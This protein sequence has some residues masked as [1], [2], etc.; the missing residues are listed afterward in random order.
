MKI[1]S[2]SITGFKAIRQ[3]SIDPNGGH[4]HLKGKNHRGKSSVI[5]SVWVALTGKDVPGVP[6]HREAVKATVKIGTTDGYLVEWSQTT[7]GTKSLKIVTPDG[8]PV[9]K[10]PAKFLK[11]LVGDISFDPME[12]S[13]K[14]PGEQKAELQKILGLDFTAIE[15]AKRV[16]LD[17]K[18]AAERRKAT[19]E[20]ELNKL[21]AVVETKPVDIQDLFA[22]QQAR[23]ALEGK[24]GQYRQRLDELDREV[25]R[26]D[27][28]I[29]AQEQAIERLRFEI[30]EREGKIADAVKL[31][32]AAKANL[33][34]GSGVVAQ[35]LAEI[36]SIPDPADRIAAASELNQRAAQ[37]ERKVAMRAEY[38]EVVVA[39]EEA[40]M[41]AQQ[42]DADKVALIA[43]AEM[44]VQ[45]LAFDETGI[46]FNGLPFDKKNQC[47]SD[48][49]KVGVGIAISLNPGVRICR[50]QDGSL[51]DD[52][53]KAEMLEILSEYGFQAFIEEVTS[54]EELTASITEIPE[55]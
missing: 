47:S 5:E 23:S 53:S 40:S 48:I 37:W 30:A 10:E 35:V 27:Q 20:A 22:K 45:G 50:I 11:Q 52:E 29:L 24:V 41:R 55:T 15:G 42:A 19:I 17:D 32:D 6:V 9:T 1:S 31:R 49:I 54:D 16:A 26:Q 44:P 33:A 3:F 14:T 28:E 36:E 2:L 4:V 46:T 8:V 18:K 21:A 39:I 38:D 12:F 25:G 51:L 7:A 34:K 43:A 13:E